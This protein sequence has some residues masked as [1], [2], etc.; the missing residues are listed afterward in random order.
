[1]Y[2]ETKQMLKD[3][4][5][6]EWKSVKKS[7]TNKTCCLCG[8]NIPVGTASQSM[9]FYQDNFNA[10]NVCNKCASEQRDLINELTTYKN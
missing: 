8:T 9:H 5:F 6:Y 10:W 4:D 7:R 2:E 3:W 1:M